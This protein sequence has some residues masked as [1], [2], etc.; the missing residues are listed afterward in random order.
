MWDHQNKIR[1]GLSGK[2]STRKIQGHSHQDLQQDEGT[3]QDTATD[4][5][6]K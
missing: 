5:E 2:T 1:S 4:L 6:Y 3:M